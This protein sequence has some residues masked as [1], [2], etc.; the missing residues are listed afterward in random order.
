MLESS[1]TDLDKL[2]MLAEKM[3]VFAN[4]RARHDSKVSLKF[5]YT[6]DERL[7]VQELKLYCENHSKVIGTPRIN[8]KLTVFDQGLSILSEVAAKGVRQLIKKSKIDI[9]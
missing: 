3:T 4:H 2:N 9:V 8:A 1:R 6:E 5:H 7:S